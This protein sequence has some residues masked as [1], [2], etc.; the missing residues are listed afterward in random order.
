MKYEIHSCYAVKLVLTCLLC[1]AAVR[2]APRGLSPE[3]PLGQGSHLHPFLRSLHVTP[4]AQGL[5]SAH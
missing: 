3:Y 2:S 4:S 5:A 1:R